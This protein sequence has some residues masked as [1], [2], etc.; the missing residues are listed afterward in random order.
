MASDGSIIAKGRNCW[1]VQLSCGRDPLTGKYRR[2]TRTCHGTKADARRVR[3]ELKRELENGLRADSVNL[4]FAEW[5]GEW[6]NIRRSKGGVSESVLRQYETRLKFMSSLL[7]DVRLNRIDARMVEQLLVAVREKRESQGSRCSDSTLRH[8][9]TLLKRCLKTACDYDMLAKNPCDRITAPKKNPAT[10]KS[11]TVDEASRL[12]RAIDESENRLIANLLEKEHRQNERGNSRERSYLLGL[13]DVSLVLMTRLGLASG[14][15]LGECL[16]L[17][18]GN[19]DFNR[20]CV[21]VVQ[22]M[23]NLDHLKPPKSLAGIRNIYIDPST[24]QHLATWYSLQGS[25]LDSIDLTIGDA[26]PVFCSAE[27][28]YIPKASFRH[29]WDSWRKEAEFPELKFH[30]LRH[31]QASQ[32][33]AAGLDVKSVQSRLGHSSA[34]LTL[35][36]YAHAMESNDEKA[37]ALIGSLFSGNSKAVPV[38]SVKNA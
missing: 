25:L 6:L 13:R 16:A 20:S 21:H 19:V 10:R 3:D 4:T 32:L 34:T 23:D 33:L 28:G 37:A 11:L 27:G 18:W 26:S 22:A 5:C 38:L 31:T 1:E 14:M 24:M 8:Y 30:E 35:D 9:F 15:R 7:G 17:T 2:I 12:L 36:C 29:W